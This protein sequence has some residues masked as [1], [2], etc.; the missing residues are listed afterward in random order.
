M[1]NMATSARSIERDDAARQTDIVVRQ[2]VD[3]IGDLLLR[4]PAHLGDHL[5]E[6]AQVAVEDALGVVGHIHDLIAAG[7]FKGV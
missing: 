2:G 5:R 6:L 1:R 3:R 7:R 4:Q